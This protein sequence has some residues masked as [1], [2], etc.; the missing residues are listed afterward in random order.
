MYGTI[1]YKAQMQDVPKHS[2]FL[3]RAHF[4]APSEGFHH[5]Q[6]AHTHPFVVLVSQCKDHATWVLTFL[7]PS[8]SWSWS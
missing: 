3:G 7:A 1:V 4:E 8:L 2:T 5:S 6:L